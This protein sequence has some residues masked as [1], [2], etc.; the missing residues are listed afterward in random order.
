M[1][2]VSLISLLSALLSEIKSDETVLL[3]LLQSRSLP[4]TE[5]P[6]EKPRSP[7]KTLSDVCRVPRLSK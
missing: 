3:I 6:A 1:V 4:R 5:R 2:C 7:F